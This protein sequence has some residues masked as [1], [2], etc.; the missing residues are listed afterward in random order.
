MS[1]KNV[2]SVVAFALAAMVCLFS[3]GL[4]AFSAGQSRAAGEPYIGLAAVAVLMALAA[5][6]CTFGAL[7]I[8]RHRNVLPP[9]KPPE[10]PVQNRGQ[11]RT[12][13]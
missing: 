2:S 11:C 7:D 9:E 5:G 8:W 6:A 12:D 3:V 10:D 1:K 13:W 4:Y